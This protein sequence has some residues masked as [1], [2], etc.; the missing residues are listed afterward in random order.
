MRFLQTVGIGFGVILLG[1]SLI[2][3]VTGMDYAWRIKNKGKS[4][5]DMMKNLDEQP[6]HKSQLE[7][8]RPTKGTAPSTEKN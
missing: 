3:S 7:R 5:E 8:R 6:R 1:T 4:F 2:I